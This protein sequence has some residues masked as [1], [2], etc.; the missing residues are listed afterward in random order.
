MKSSA[1]NPRL[2]QAIEDKYNALKRKDFK[3]SKKLR[4]KVL[5][6]LRNGADV[7]ARNNYGDTPLHLAA[8]RSEHNGATVRI[9]LDDYQADF[10]AL[11]NDGET[12]LIGAVWRGNVCAVRLLVDKALDAGEFRKMA[13]VRA[14]FGNRHGKNAVEV[15]QDGVRSSKT[16]AREKQ[17]YSEIIEILYAATERHDIEN[18]QRQQA[19]RPR[20]PVGSRIRVCW[21][22]EGDEAD[23]WYPGTVCRHE[24]DLCVVAYEDGSEV[25]H[26][27]PGADTWWRH[28]TLA[29][30]DPA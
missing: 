29:T 12:A 30:V 3:L 24:G 22:H 4:R 7:G 19:Q 25:A 26:H 1:R 17:H 13:D 5:R 8:F 28:E 14:T 2:H 10:H 23:E 9:L 16:T 6:L 20:P 18:F 15:A 27:L 11:T 21:E